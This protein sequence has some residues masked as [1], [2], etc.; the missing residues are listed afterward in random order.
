ML[1][2][3]LLIYYKTRPLTNKKLTLKHI[4]MV[5]P[6][7]CMVIAILLFTSHSVELHM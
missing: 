2:G 7:L 4:S 6:Y 5:S 1:G 3:K